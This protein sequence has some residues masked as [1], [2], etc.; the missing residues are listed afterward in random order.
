MHIVVLGITSGIAAHK[1]LDLIRLLKLDGIDVRVILT[2]AARHMVDATEI[3]TLTGHTAYTELFGPEFEY[4]SILK[5][6]TVD[7]IRLADSADVFVIAPAT[8]NTIAKLAH[9]LA[10]NMLTTTALATVAPII[11]CPSMNVHMWHNPVTRDNMKRI[12]QLGHIVVD[13]QAGML[14]CGYEGMGRLADVSIIHKAITEQLRRTTQ[15]KGKKILVTAGGSI[16]RIDDIRAI[17]NRSSGKM[18]VA[19]AEACALRGADVLLLRATSAVSP[20]YTM[21]QETYSTADDIAVLLQRHIPAC[22]VVFHTAALSDF[23]ID[24][25]R[26]GKLKSD[27]PATLKL[28]PRVKLLDRIKTWNPD[29]YLVA[30]KAEFNLS[31]KALV[32]RAKKRMNESSADA[33]IANDVAPGD[34]GFES[35]DNEVTIITSDSPPLT[36]PLASKRDVAEQIIT[37]L[38]ARFH[39][40]V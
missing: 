27:K 15:L 20:R 6:R 8:A 22:D 39:P 4:A 21:R 14:A 29:I 2:E 37:H 23:T 34:R 31:R 25:P 28:K 24:N 3:N 38:A 19:I 11:V 9:G 5:N 35:D 33:I 10:D 1:T 17:T 13:P 40:A 32:S 36:I 30:F 12:K 18:G 16:E 7:H 26:H